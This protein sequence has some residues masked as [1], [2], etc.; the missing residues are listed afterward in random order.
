MD[1]EHYHLKIY[2]K[3]EFLFGKKIFGWD[4]AQKGNRRI[5][6]NLFY[7]MSHMVFS[8]L[9]VHRIAHRIQP[10]FGKGVY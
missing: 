3:S 4:M 8:I 2:S 7:A 9:L 1:L 6:G 10:Y 5:D